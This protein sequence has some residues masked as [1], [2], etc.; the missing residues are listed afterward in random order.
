MTWFAIIEHG[1]ARWLE[2]GH[3]RAAPSSW[4]DKRVQQRARQ[5]LLAKLPFFSEAKSGR[6][7][8][9]AHALKLVAARDKN[10]EY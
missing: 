9:M 7:A 1:E 8:V 6:M 2:I 10:I 3:G 5:S 4:R